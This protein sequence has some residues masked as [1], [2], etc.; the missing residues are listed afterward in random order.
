MIYIL[1]LFLLL[2]VRIRVCVCVYLCLCVL[3]LFNLLFML[4]CNCHWLFASR[5]LVDYFRGHGRGW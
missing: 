5:A 1:V 2:R 3:N 4:C